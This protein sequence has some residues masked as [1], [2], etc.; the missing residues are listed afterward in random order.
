MCS[1]EIGHG[2]VPGTGSAAQSSASSAELERVK[3]EK[4]QLESRLKTVN[5]ELGLQVPLA[6]VCVLCVWCVRVSMCVASLTGPMRCADQ[7]LQQALCVELR[8]QAGAVCRED[9]RGSHEGAARGAARRRGRR[10]VG[11]VAGVEEQAGEGRAGAEQGARG[12]QEQGLDAA[13]RGEERA[14]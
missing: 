5:E 6:T 4:A 13:V 12:E 2:V 7:E 9:G 1:A 3:T 14:R 8:A 11:G 10:G